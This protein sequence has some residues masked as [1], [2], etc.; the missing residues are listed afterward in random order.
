MNYVD[1]PGTAEVGESRYIGERCKRIERRGGGVGVRRYA[2]VGTCRRLEVAGGAR[3]S[4]GVFVFTSSVHASST[5][6]GGHGIKQR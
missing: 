1:L 3:D 5:R 4:C 2:A 6:E